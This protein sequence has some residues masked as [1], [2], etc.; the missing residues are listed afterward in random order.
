MDNQTSDITALLYSLSVHSDEPSYRRIFD[1]LFPPLKRFAYT[2]LKNSEQAE[3]I[4]SDVLI[5]VWENR[6]KLVAIDNIRVYLFVVA[7]NKCL[8]L[9]KSRQSNPVV[10]LNDISIDIAF[11][12]KNPEQLCINSEVRKKIEKTI[13]LLPQRCKLIFKLVKEEN[14]SYREVAAILNI[15]VKTVDAQ[16]VTAFKKITEAVRLDYATAF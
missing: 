12:G 5:V 7:R 9:L 6:H 1:L 13:N 16:L 15:S 3:E 2:L 14:M 8:N 10:S 11:T 4:A